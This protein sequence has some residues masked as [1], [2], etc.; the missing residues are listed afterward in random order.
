[1][2]LATELYP[3]QTAIF[4]ADLTNGRAY[5]TEMRLSVVVCTECIVG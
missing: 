5:A 2:R 4:L 3:L 1:M